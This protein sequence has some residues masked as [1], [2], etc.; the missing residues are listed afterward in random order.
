MAGAPLLGSVI[1]HARTLAAQETADR[2]DRE[3][4]ADFTSR[5]DE[6]AFAALVRRHAGLVWA[7]CRSVLGHEQD[8]EDAFQASFLVLARRAAS[9]PKAATLGGWLHGVAY[10]TALR[11][12]RDAARRRRHE[13]QAR[14]MAQTEVPW[15]AAWRE[16]QAVLAEEVERLPEAQRVV[17]VFC[18]LEGGSRAEA[19]RVLHLKE[20][21]V[22][23]RLAHAREQLRRRLARRG[24]A[25]PA[26]L[27]YAA[28]TSRTAAAA[29]AG[30]AAVTVRRVLSAVAGQTP[31]EFSAR[32]ATLAQGMMQAMMLGRLKLGLVLALMLGIFAAGTGLLTLQAPAPK[33]SQAAGREP[34]PTPAHA[35]QRRRI[36]RYGDPLPAGAVARIG[37]V[38]FQRGGRAWM[39]VFSPDGKMVASTGYDGTVNLWDVGTGKEVRRFIADDALWLR[40]M[41]FTP[42]GKTLIVAGADTFARFWDVA[43][44]RDVGR[45]AAPEG[46]IGSL[47]LSPDGKTLAGS[48]GEDLYLWDITTRKELWRMK[49]PG[50]GCTRGIAFSPD[51][52]TLAVA[53]MD[54]SLCLY[55]VA[56]GRESGR[57][58]VAANPNSGPGLAYSPD[59]KLLALAGADLAV[60]VWSIAAGREVARS[61]VHAYSLECVVF[62][63]DG[64][65]VASAPGDGPVRLCDAH[66]GKE[67]RALECRPDTYTSVAFSPDGRSLAGTANSGK[68]YLWDLATGEEQP[69]SAGANQG[70]S[71]A[72]LLPDGKTVVS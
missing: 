4:L 44:G 23:S 47:T 11:A 66:T 21:T 17:F 29:P 42:D 53:S 55:D 37:T 8:A 25:L 65:F 1:R 54:K 56:A 18:C 40:Q 30:L 72:R 15:Q 32:A 12:K 43:T 49:R 38:R 64:R 5:K 31:A 22:S 24:I 57:I 59:G 7:V 9:I 36:D 62:S 14:A 63:P 58:P 26:V 27:E 41:A 69:I 35:A 13:G 19:A 71:H 34:P 39:V 50:T 2:T 20:G 10:R 61:K 60:H 45:L 33:P 52:R 68:I 3:L 16:V 51:S 70:Y 6:S 28:L 67:G 46:G 48:N